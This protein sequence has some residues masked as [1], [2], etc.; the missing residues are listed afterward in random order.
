MEFPTLVNWTTPF[1][2]YGVLG[3]I[4]YLMERS[5]RIMNSG[6]PDQTLCSAVADLGLHY[7]PMFYKKDT[8]IFA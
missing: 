8:R 2:F 1:A 6:Y 7:L 5:V 3:S 4:F